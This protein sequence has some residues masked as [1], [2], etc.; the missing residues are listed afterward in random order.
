MSMSSKRSPPSPRLVP[1]GKGEIVLDLVKTW[2]AWRMWQICHEDSPD[3]QM[4]QTE[5]SRK[6]GV[7]GSQISE[8]KSRLPGASF[9]DSWIQVVDYL[10]LSPEEAFAEA[11][12]WRGTES[13]RRW[14]NLE[15]PV[16]HSRRLPEIAGNLKT[17]IIRL[18]RH[19]KI[20]ISPRVRIELRRKL[21]RGDWSV[22]E[23]SVIVT[24]FI[25]LDAD[26]R[27]ARRE[28]DDR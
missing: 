16:P 23:W 8:L 4:T 11:R 28:T 12:E 3:R 22:E 10:E 17:A 20:E 15:S 6:T 7:S 27:L 13:H 25:E 2:L 21:R 26:G 5:L 1:P 24:A 9:G 19:D 18:Q 14:V